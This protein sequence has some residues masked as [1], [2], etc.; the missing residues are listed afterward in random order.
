MK[1]NNQNHPEPSLSDIAIIGMSCRF[2]GAKNLAEF[3]ENLINGK[4]TIQRFTQEE[5]L[6][7]GESSEK[8]NDEHYVNAR[9]IVADPELFDASFFGF[10]A[11]DARL[12]DPQ[13]RFFLECGWEAL[14]VAGYASEKCKEL[15][16]VYASMAESTYLQE[17]LV[18]NQHIM[19]SEDWLQLRIANSLT[20]LSTQLSYRLNLKGP[21]VN[22]T[23]ACS[24]S[25][26]TIISACK[27]L[28]DYDCDIAI[29]GSS[30]VSI[31][32]H[33]GYLYQKGGIESVDGHCRAFD[34]EASGTVFSD[35]VGVVILKRLSDAIQDQDF[36]YATIKS[37]NINNDGSDKAGYTAPSIRG[38]ARCIVS[39]A[40]FAEIDLASLGYIETH[41]TGTAMGDPIEINALR[42]AFETQTQQQQ[43]CAIG[44]IKTNIGHADIAAGMAS[45]IKTA[46]MLNH[47][48]IPASLHYKESNPAIDF[49]QTPFYVNATLSPWETKTT[50]PRRAGINSSG[51]GGTN[52]F[53][54]L[55]EHQKPSA[56]T[57]DLNSPQLVLLSAKTQAAL[58]HSFNNLQQHI[59]DNPDLNLSNMAYTLQVGRNDFSHRIA[60]ICNNNDE[61]STLKPFSASD[62]DSPSSTLSTLQRRPISGHRHDDASSL[63]PVTF[64]Q[65]H[66]IS[67]QPKIVF[68][69]PGQGAQYSGMCEDLYHSEPEFAKLINECLAH[70]AVDIQEDVALLLLG[71]DHAANHVTRTSITQPALFIFEYA[72]ATFLINLGILP[73]ALIGHSIGEYVAACISGVMGF[74]TALH[75][76][77]LR[78]HLMEMTEP[79]TMVALACNEKDTLDLIQNY[80]VSIAACN[81]SSNTV[82][83]GPSEKVKALMKDLQ[84]KHIIAKPLNTQHAFHSDLMLPVLENFVQALEKI[85]FQH[86][87]IPFISN[88]SGEWAQDHEVTNPEYWAKHILHTV[89]F[90]DGLELLLDNDFNLLLEVGPG[91]TLTNFAR[92]ISK[93]DTKILIRNTNSRHPGTQSNATQW[94][95]VVAEIWLRGGQIDWAYF[96]RHHTKGRI[97]LPTY[98][99]QRQRFWVLP[100]QHDDTAKSYQQ[101]AY[102]QWFYEPSW[103]RTSFMT[104]DLEQPY[105]WI[106]LQDELGIGT[107]IQKYLLEHHHIVFLVKNTTHFI[108]S[109][110]YE[111]G[112]DIANPDHYSLLIQSI[113][114]GTDLPLAVLNL[115]P[116]TSPMASNNDLSPY[117][118]ACFY[119]T[120]FLSQALVEHPHHQAIPITV[121]GNELVSLISEKV[122]PVKATVMGPCRVIPLEHEQL[123]IKVIDI[124]PLQLYKHK[125]SLVSHILADTLTISNQDAMIAYRKNYRWV[126]DFSNMVLPSKT[127]VLLH[128]DSVFL[129]TGGLG[130]I[131]LTL[132]HHIAQQT[133]HSKLLLIART[134][135]PVQSE[136]DD[137]LHTHDHADPVSKKI[138]K[139]QQIIALGAEIYIYAVNIAQEKELTP[140]IQTI[141]NQ[142]G[143]INGVIHCAGTPGGGLAQFKTKEM[144]NKVFEP[145]VFGTY[146]LCK[147]LQHEPL[148]FFVLCSSINAIMGDVSL[149]DYCAA[150]ACLDAFPYSNF[151]QDSHTIFTTIN[152]NTWQDVGMAVETARP[153]DISYFKR[154]NDIKPHE[155]AQIFSDSLSLQTKQII[156]STLPLM[157]FIEHMHA[158]SE[159]I[160]QTPDLIERHTILTDEENTY[161][162]PRTEVEKQIAAIWQDIFSLDK[163]GIQDDF[164]KLGGH[165]LKA[166][167]LL[168]KIERQFK[169]TISVSTFLEHATTIEKLAQVITS[170][171]QIFVPSSSIVIPIRSSGHHPPLFCFH[172]VAG[173]IFCYANLA[174]YLKYDA[175]IY[176]IQDPSIAQGK[177]LFDTMEDMASTYIK[178]IKKIQATG[179]YYLGGLSFGATLAAEVA[180]QLRLNGDTIKVLFFFDGWAKFSAEQNIEAIFKD[181]IMQI[182]DNRPDS[183]KLSNMAWQRMRMLLN[184]DVKPIQEPVFLYKAQTLLPEYIEINEPYN[185]WTKHVV[186]PIHL[187]HVPGDHET[188][189]DEPNIKTLASLLDTMFIEIK[190]GAIA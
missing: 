147:V 76:I 70:L 141:K 41:G 145:K 6:S 14:E 81:T 99:F 42:M 121:I 113:L 90:A 27:A 11:A 29:A 71:V 114:S 189:L 46:L 170:G 83:S 21:S 168:N 190:A 94:L 23:T 39:A 52:A 136:W 157:S 93:N 186:N 18:K 154:N 17:H 174:K 69:F 59:H 72:L 54:I 128:N 13:H 182:Y 40:N 5:L 9:G 108:H 187:A 164:F 77:Q 176:G 167:H 43:F 12:L 155:G 16:G 183:Q 151:F 181:A 149:V 123:K 75:I 102:A 138:L 25:L 111:Y 135:F 32:Q 64:Y 117:L 7:S 8:I 175:P 112:I 20:T 84:E 134:R 91:H 120:L 150:N 133:K 131:G 129:I 3:W 143:T 66:S 19:Q 184:Y 33:K 48:C 166:L 104:V 185:Y 125:L 26:V 96:N 118:D 142:F 163:I 65:N 89:R 116:L 165:S 188:I 28:L 50:G 148:D 87:T 15:I 137:W 30:V 1:E 34:A 177:L 153:T 82:I 146:L 10:S 67:E 36:I 159:Q 80:P 106:L 79:G 4:E 98:P 162:P 124:G 92:E 31:P 144:A 24:S 158:Q 88:I 35:G 105:A 62:L 119:S 63:F 38:Q 22:V 55:E 107:A 127:E 115:F 85:E 100:S 103:K 126:Q 60:I 2:P 173:T 58:K 139:L 45:I 61:V 57:A 68:M 95:M 51:I 47:Q 73:D 160:Y 161:H 86:P 130:G 180:R 44:S 110:K 152:W 122:S 132:A 178:E 171:T 172:P 140:F 74:K 109:F 156:I 78:A 53:L 101:Q 56:P 169:V 179:P 37:W 49:R 97:P